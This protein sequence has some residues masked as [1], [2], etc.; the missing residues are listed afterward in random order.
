LDEHRADDEAVIRHLFRETKQRRIL[1]PAESINGLT[2]GSL[3]Q[4]GDEAVS[5]ESRAQVIP[6]RT[7]LPAAYSAQGRGFR[8][9]VKPDVLMPGGRRLFQQKLPMAGQPWIGIRGQR[10]LGQLVAVPGAPGQVLTATSTGTSN[11]AALTSRSAVFMH[12]AVEQLLQEPGTEA[13][14][15]VP[16]G[17]L[18][19]A[20]LTHT[21]EWPE[22]T[23]ALCSQ[24]LKGD[25]DRNRLKD[26][27]AGMLGYGVL[28]PVR[29]T[30]CTPTRATAGGGTIGPERRRVHRLPIPSC[31]HARNE[32]RRVTLTLAWFTPINPADRRYRVARLRL[33]SPRDTTQ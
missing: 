25:V 9:S 29:G 26:H 10:Q 20:L 8:R 23:E 21:A 2:V 18:L 7:D 32:W 19:R 6:T 15:E 17:L 27:L 16:M 31:L 24:A 4:D 5:R 13:L 28:R 14:R 22:E 11:A 3:N 33:E 30:E 12:A 1:C